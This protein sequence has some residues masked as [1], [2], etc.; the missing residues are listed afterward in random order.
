MKSSYNQT[1]IIIFI[2]IFCAGTFYFYKTQS[3]SM[4]TISS[5]ALPIKEIPG[6][7]LGGLDSSLFFDDLENINSNAT[8]NSVDPKNLV[9]NNLRFEEPPRV[10][11]AAKKEMLERVFSKAKVE[12][13]VPEGFDWEER[14]NEYPGLTTVRS[15]HPSKDVTIESLIS[16]KSF[17]AEDLEEAAQRL[18]RST[19]QDFEPVVGYKLQSKN[20]KNIKIFQLDDDNSP[21]YII[22]GTANGR[23]VYFGISGKMSDINSELEKIK[24]TFS[25]L[26]I[27]K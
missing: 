14:E 2:A 25:N 1:L 18:F 19:A 3:A 26:K 5:P 22:A 20:V 24:K 23:E 9:P 8:V 10:S 16:E 11:S 12:P 15:F 17:T 4:E 13:L 6:S 27:K 7:K 21:I